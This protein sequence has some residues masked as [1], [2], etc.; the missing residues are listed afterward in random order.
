MRQIVGGTNSS[1]CIL[2]EQIAIFDTVWLRRMVGWPAYTNLLQ[3]TVSTS[4][5]GDANGNSV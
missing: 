2:Q 4:N 5:K 1:Q 3:I